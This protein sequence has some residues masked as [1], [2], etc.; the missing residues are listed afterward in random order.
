[1]KNSAMA[2]TDQNSY[3][4]IEIITE[5]NLTIKEAKKLLAD[6][7]TQIEIIE[8]EET[9]KKK[10]NPDPEVSEKRVFAEKMGIQPSSVYHW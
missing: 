7:E 1:M 4:Q 3:Y 10:A 5:Q 8:W 2:I 9:K 6:L